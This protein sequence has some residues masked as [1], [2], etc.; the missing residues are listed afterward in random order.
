[1]SKGENV[2]RKAGNVIGALYKGSKF[3]AKG[4]K[5]LAVGFGSSVKEGPIGQDVKL[6]CAGAK[7]LYGRAVKALS[8]IGEEPTSV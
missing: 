1:M 4:G 7:S 5:N 8:R 3:A 2:G 6:G